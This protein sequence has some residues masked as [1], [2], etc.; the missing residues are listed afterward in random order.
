VLREGMQGKGLR[1]LGGP[2]MVEKNGQ[3]RVQRLH[4]E[5]LKA[6]IE[7]QSRAL[8]EGKHK[9]YFQLNDNTRWERADEKEDKKNRRDGIKKNLV[10]KELGGGRK[11]PKHLGDNELASLK[12]EVFEGT[13]GQ[14]LGSLERIHTEERARSGTF[15]KRGAVGPTRKK[16]GTVRVNKVNRKPDRR[17]EK[18]KIS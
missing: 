15:R 9:D 1:N 12:K 6:I 13:T 11:H 17:S 7:L 18:N 8:R 10:Q 4:A 2:P 5:K 3:G 16:K 14:L